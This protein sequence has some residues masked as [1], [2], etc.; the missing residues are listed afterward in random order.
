VGPQR[1]AKLSIA[2]AGM[3]ISVSSAAA[4]AVAVGF[5]A[6]RPRGLLRPAGSPIGSANAAM[7][8]TAYLDIAAAIVA[9]I[10]MK[11]Q[12]LRQHK[13]QFH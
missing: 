11:S 13:K 5:M 6:G 4:N 1:H 9:T 2:V 10:E 8:G 12:R 3:A 7:T